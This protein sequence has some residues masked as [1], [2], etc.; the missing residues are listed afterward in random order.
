V[1]FL[2]FCVRTLLVVH[3]IAI[4][5]CFF[6]CIHLLDIVTYHCRLP[7]HSYLGEVGADGSVLG[8][9][10]PRS[11]LSRR[12]PHP[13]EYFSSVARAIIIC[14][15]GCTILAGLAKVHGPQLQL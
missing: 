9:W 2:P 6:V 3:S 5:G 14:L 11:Q 7:Y 10:S 1:V 8:G 15:Q 4:T 13:R 12:E